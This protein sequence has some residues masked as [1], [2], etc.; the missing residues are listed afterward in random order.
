MCIHF[1]SPWERTKEEMFFLPLFGYWSISK[2]RKDGRNWTTWKTKKRTSSSFSRCVS[3]IGPKKKTPRLDYIYCSSIAILTRAISFTLET[4]CTTWCFYRH[5]TAMF[6]YFHSIYE[7]ISLQL[8]ICWVKDTCC[9]WY[10]LLKLNRNEQIETG[11]VSRC[12][13]L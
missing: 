11:D 13:S 6:V 12:S 7:S 4:D 8:F 2:W 3:L 10:L 1:S 9:H 5:L